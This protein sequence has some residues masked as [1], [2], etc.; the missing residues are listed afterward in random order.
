MFCK[1]VW[2]LAPVLSHSGNP[3]LPSEQPLLSLHTSWGSSKLSHVEI[4]AAPIQW[5]QSTRIYKE[6]NEIPK[7]KQDKNHQQMHEDYSSNYQGK[8]PMKTMLRL[9]LSY[10][11]QKNWLQE[12]LWQR[13]MVRSCGK[14]VFIQGC[15]GCNKLVQPLWKSVGRFFQN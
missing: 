5:D 1:C 3:E 2:N 11:R 6:L 15:W 14:G 8:M 9:V 4:N 10:P 7:L 13:E 12:N